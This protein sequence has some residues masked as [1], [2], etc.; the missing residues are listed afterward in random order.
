LSAVQLWN[1]CKLFGLL[2]EAISKRSDATMNKNRDVLFTML[3]AIRHKAQFIATVTLPR[4]QA[5]ASQSTTTIFSFKGYQQHLH[6]TSTTMQTTSRAGADSMDTTEGPTQSSSQSHL[7][8]AAQNQNSDD[9]QNTITL[10]ANQ[11]SSPMAML[12]NLHTDNEHDSV[13]D[14]RMLLRTMFSTASTILGYI[15]KQPISPS[16]SLTHEEFVCVG[17]LFEY[18]IQCMDIVLYSP[19]GKSKAYVR[20]GTPFS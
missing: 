9:T 5:Q 17:G 6:K 20:S 15:T 19:D 4:L 1:F 13:R 8:S 18:G 2:E 11:L 12:A 3:N 7:A 10:G 14:I 16:R